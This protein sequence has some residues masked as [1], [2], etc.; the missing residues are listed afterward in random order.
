MWKN[1]STASSLSPGSAG[2]SGSSCA[3]LVAMLRWV[4]ITPLG[5]P[6]VPE[7]YGSAATSCRRVD[8]RAAARARCSRACRARCVPSARSQTKISSTPPAH[9]AACRAVSSSGETVT[10]QRAEESRSCLANS[11]GGGERM[12]GGDGR[13]RAGGAVEDGGVGDGVGAVQGEHVALAQARVGERG[14]DPAVEEVELGVR[15]GGAVHPVDQR[16]RVAEPGGPAE[17]RVVDRSSTAGRRRTRCGTRF[18]PLAVW[19]AR[20]ASVSTTW[21]GPGSGGTRS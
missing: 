17:H 6:V 10:I 15:E 4:S 2:I 18:R 16:D 7:E 21:G 19:T 5:T 20:I 1:G 8:G 13:A 3:R 12:D 11:S 9:S 14:G